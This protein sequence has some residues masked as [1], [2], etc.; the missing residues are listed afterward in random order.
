M[1][2]NNSKIYSN[3]IPMD[4]D[5]WPT[6]SVDSVA[7]VDILCVVPTIVWGGLC[8]VAFRNVNWSVLSSF[9]IILLNRRMSYLFTWIAYLLMCIG[10]DKDSYAPKM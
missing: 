8:W 10:P 1:F 3:H 2:N 6:Y 5:Y 4:L 7:V 9:G